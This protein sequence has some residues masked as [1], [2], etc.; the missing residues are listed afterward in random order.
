MNADMW[1]LTRKPQHLMKCVQ[2]L[3][4]FRFV[5]RQGKPVISHWPT[6]WLG[7]MTFWRAQ[8][9][10]KSNCPSRMF[11]AHLNPFWKTPPFWKSGKIW[12]M[13][14][15]FSH[16]TGSWWP[17]L[18][19]RCW[20]LMRFTE[21]CMFTDW[22]LCQKDICLMKPFQLNHFWEAENLQSPLTKLA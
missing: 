16:A 10:P 14:Q 5:F 2:S 9:L 12:N 6:K 8:N 11:C 13:T 3:S 1:P 17:Q 18:M 19:I 20:Y 21:D 15:K 4:A 7:L 22:I